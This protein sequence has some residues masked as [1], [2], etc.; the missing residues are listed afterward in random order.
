MALVT[1]SFRRSSSRAYRRIRERLGLVTA[2]L[3]EDIAG[4]ASL[5]AFTR[6]PVQAAFGVNDELPRC[7]QQTVGL[8]GEL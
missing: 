5:Q 4:S 6:E 1:A 3:A 8:N 2:T 7:N